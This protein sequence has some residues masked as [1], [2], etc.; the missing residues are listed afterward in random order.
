[1]LNEINKLYHK[2]NLKVNSIERNLNIKKWN[3][4]K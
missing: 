4:P 2:L 3:I 1:M